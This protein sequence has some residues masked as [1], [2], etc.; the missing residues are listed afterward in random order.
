MMLNFANQR[1]QGEEF[2]FENFQEDFLQIQFLCE[3]FFTEKK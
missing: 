2:Y 1:N 3:F